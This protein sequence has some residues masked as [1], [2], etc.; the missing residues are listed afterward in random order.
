LSEF[1]KLLLESC[2]LHP[3]GEIISWAAWILIFIM[4]LIFISK[5]SCK[6]LHQLLRYASVAWQQTFNF[7]SLDQT[8]ICDCSQG[9]LGL[10]EREKE[11]KR[12]REKAGNCCGFILQ[13][14]YH[15]S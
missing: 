3:E 10:R 1:P 5:L 15:T 7:E 13:V 12:E 9:V 8:E 6:L 14:L 11:R 4:V 2:D